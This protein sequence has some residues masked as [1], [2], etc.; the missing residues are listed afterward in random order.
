MIYKILICMSLGS[1][2]SLGT[3]TI[4]MKTP[5][6]TKMRGDCSPPSSN[7]LFL[8]KSFKFFFLSSGY[9]WQV[10]YKIKML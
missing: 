10:H 5:L 3:T 1:G 6:L 4:E 7:L 8:K 9:Q 2:S